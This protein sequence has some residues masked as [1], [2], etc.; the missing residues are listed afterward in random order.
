[1]I[2]KTENVKVILSNYG[3]MKLDIKMLDNSILWSEKNIE[4][5]V[6]ADIETRSMAANTEN[7]GSFSLNTSSEKTPNIAFGLDKSR[8]RYE[9][10]ISEMKYKRN[11]FQ[12][13]VSSIEIFADNLEKE[14]SDIFKAYYLES[15]RKPCSVIAERSCLSERRIGQIII[16]LAETYIN[17]VNFNVDALIEMLV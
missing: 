15:P 9:E 12:M 4:N 2:T 16:S 1:M 8:K 10:A 5:A 13:A 7:N 17:S 6:E 11:I 14:P 3:R